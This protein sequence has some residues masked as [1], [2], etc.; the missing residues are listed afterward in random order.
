M[1]KSGLF[2]GS[3]LNLAQIRDY[4]EDLDHKDRSRHRLFI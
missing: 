3:L 4:P 1:L 2:P